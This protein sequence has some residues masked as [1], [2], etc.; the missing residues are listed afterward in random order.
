MA[1]TMRGS[2]PI[3]YEII[4]EGMLLGQTIAEQLESF[5]IPKNTKC[6]RRRAILLKVLRVYNVME[7]VSGHSLHDSDFIRLPIPQGEFKKIALIIGEEE[8][9]LKLKTAC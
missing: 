8:D 5:G 3:G 1:K 4:A 2:K 7:S 9:R 6:D